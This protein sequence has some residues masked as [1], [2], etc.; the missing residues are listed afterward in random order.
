MR[1]VGGVSVVRDGARRRKIMASE[2][3]LKPSATSLRRLGI[4]ACVLAY[5]VAGCGHSAAMRPSQSVQIA[6]AGCGAGHIAFRATT[7]GAHE[8]TFTCGEGS[9]F[10]GG[11]RAYI[12]WLSQPVTSKF[13]TIIL[14]HGP[15]VL[16]AMVQRVSNPSLTVLHGTIPFSRVPEGAQ[17]GSRPSEPMWGTYVQSVYRGAHGA[18]GA[19]LA[20]GHF[21]VVED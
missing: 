3:G 14:V 2:G 20:V 8:K 11:T 15:T 4:A 6:L 16:W 21:S 7:P 19:R 1:V 17:P 10:D 9:W 5:M 12:A 18:S 13:V